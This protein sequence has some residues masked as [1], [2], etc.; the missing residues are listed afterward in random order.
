MTKLVAWWRTLRAAL[1]RTRKTTAAVWSTLTPPALVGVLALLGV[2]IDTA[3][4]VLI[5][6]VGT[7]LLA[8]AAV[9]RAKANEPPA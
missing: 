8:P 1:A 9:Y 3:R 6:G 2:H 4:A 5:L 7:A